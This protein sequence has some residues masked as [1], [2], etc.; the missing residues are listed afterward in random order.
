MSLL[1]YLKKIENVGRRAYGPVG[2]EEE[3]IEIVR[4]AEE[5]QESR[6]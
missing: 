4:T 6:K 5:V 3:T 2:V 1:Y